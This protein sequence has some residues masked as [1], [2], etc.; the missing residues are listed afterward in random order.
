MELNDRGVIEVLHERA[1]LGVSEPD[2]EALAAARVVTF[3]VKC[4]NLATS[5]LQQALAA[6]SAINLASTGDWPELSEWKKIL[7]QDFVDA[8]APEK[9]SEEEQQWLIWWRSLTPALQKIEADKW[10]L[11]DWLYWMEPS[12]RSWYWW[13]GRVVDEGSIAVAVKILD[14]PFPWGALK[15]LFISAG[16][17]SVE[18]EFG[19]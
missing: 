1:R 2:V 18:S 19:E 11:A 16:A 14:W 10:S 5:V 6:M 12:N 13:T 7:A 4:G 15:I 9:T 3:E 17:I 8:F